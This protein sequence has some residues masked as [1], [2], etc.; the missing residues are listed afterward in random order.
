VPL[1]VDASDQRLLRA[2]DIEPVLKAWPE[3]PFILSVPKIEQNDRWFYYLWERY[4]S[5]YVDLPGYQ[6][7]GGIASVVQRFGPRRLIYGSRYPYFTP[8]QTMLQVVYS[9]I[10]ESARRAIAGD[11]LRGLLK[12]VRL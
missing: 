1:L 6:V 7:L 2:A 10:D 12:E 8:L 3:M 11:T 5:F 9:E 4:D